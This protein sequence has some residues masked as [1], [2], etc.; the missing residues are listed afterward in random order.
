[1]DRNKP[2]GIF[3]SG[4][5]G[6]TLASQLTL[7]LPGEDLLY[8]GDT[9]HLPYGDK[10]T[11]AIQA[12]SVKISQFLLDKGVKAILIACNS[13]SA[14]AFEL[15]K[16]YV[17]S[18]ALVFNVIDPVVEFLSDRYQGEKVGLIGTKQTVNSGIFARK[19]EEKGSGVLLSSLATPLLAPMIEEGFFNNRISL[20]IIEEYLQNPSLNDI[21]AI[22]LACTHYPLIAAEIN[23]YFSGNVDIVDSGRMVASAVKEK[24]AE[25]ELL[26]PQPNGSKQFFVSDYTIAFENA[27]QIF[28]GGKLHLEHFPLWD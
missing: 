18:K 16:E 27:T 9:A 3:D 2:I 14:A 21:S 12:Y 8:F 13:A 25:L 17:G 15:V 20:G 23:G 4:I 6:L 11:A 1:M 7:M 19:L 28:F 10:S 24:L 22:V 5:G 26:N